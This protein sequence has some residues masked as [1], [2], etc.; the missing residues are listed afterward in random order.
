MFKREGGVRRHAIEIEKMSNLIIEAIA[1][2]INKI[3]QE[4]H[5]YS[6]TLGCAITSCLNTA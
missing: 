3:R 4:G 6:R 2:Q 5:P 1:M